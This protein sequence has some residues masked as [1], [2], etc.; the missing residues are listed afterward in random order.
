M[1]EFFSSLENQV[2]KVDLVLHRI[3]VV[4]DARAIG[5]IG[6]GD[7]VADV[8]ELRLEREIRLSRRVDTQTIEAL[9]GGGQKGFDVL[10]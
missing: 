10:F 8:L 1:I 5:K 3:D 9:G 2:E 7:G 6:E 4:I